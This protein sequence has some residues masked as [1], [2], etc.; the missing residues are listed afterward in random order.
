MGLN[1]AG[2]RSQAVFPRGQYWDLSCSIPFL[3]SQMRALSADDTK[4]VG[5]VNLP[6]DRK[7]LQRNLYRLDCWAEASGMKLNKTKFW[8]LHF[9]HN[10]PRQHYGLGAVWLN[11]CT[12]ETDLGGTGQCSAEHEPAMNVPR[13]P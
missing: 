4:L 5:S 2:N 3:M 11:D 13:W 7:A 1:S 12:E 6:G 9:V 8:V 10:N